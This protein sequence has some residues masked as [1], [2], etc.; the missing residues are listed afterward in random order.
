MGYLP[1]YRTSVYKNLDYDA[2]THMCLAFF[3]PN[4][5]SLA[6][7]HKFDSDQLIKDIVKKAH[8]NGVVVLGSYGGASGKAAYKQILTSSSKRTTLV[9]NM[10]AHAKKF[11]YDGIDIDIEAST[12]DTD[13]WNNYDS[14]ISLLRKRCD[15]E[16]LL[17]T[18]AVAEW[19]GDAI[20]SSTLKKL[21]STTLVS[22]S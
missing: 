5:S 18:T 14:F 20:S 17:L 11:G 19:Y 22:P 15:E 9:E 16:G 13:I 21:K 6:I 8:D 2:L 10:I 1:Y 4:A 3:N 7:E 12:S